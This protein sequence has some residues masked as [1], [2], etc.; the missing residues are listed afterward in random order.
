MTAA[1]GLLAVLA[2]AQVLY[3]RGAQPRPPL[4]TRALL[5]LMLGTSWTEAA[6]A[7]GT[8]RALAVMLWPA[9]LGFAAEVV[10]VASGR[11]FGRYSYSDKLGPRIAGVPLLAAA[12]WSMMARPA[13]VAAGWISPRPVTRAPLAAAALT[14]WDVYLDPRMVS[15]GYWTWPAGG[16]YEGVPATNFAGWL[17]V[18]LGVFTAMAAL[19]GGPPEPRDDRALIFY[20]WAWLGEAFA[21]ALL[22]RRRRT[23]I[24]GASAMGAIALPAL[25][26]RRRRCGS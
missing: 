3:G 9:A 14:A 17:I 10:G 2:G 20:A 23:A 26:A 6:A 12:A 11:P 24:A 25:R 21:N 7:R 4:A 8:R 18:G 19:D 1:D 15:E 16:R 5:A 22:W 13:W